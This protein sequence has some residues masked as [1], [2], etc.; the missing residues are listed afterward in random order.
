[1]EIKTPGPKSTVGWRHCWWWKATLRGTVD[2]E[3]GTYV[4][5]HA[6]AAP[7]TLHMCARLFT[8]LPLPPPRPSSSRICSNPHGLIRKYALNICRQCFRERANHIGFYKVGLHCVHCVC[9]VS[10]G[11]WVSV[12]YSENFREVYSS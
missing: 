4:H 12:M 1:M 10:W 3:G 5:T 9:D 11:E 2:I 7:Y 8:L 6:T